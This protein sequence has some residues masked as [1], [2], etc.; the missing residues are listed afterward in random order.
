[1]LRFRSHSTQVARTETEVHRR[2]ASNRY[3]AQTPAWHA[4]YVLLQLQGVVEFGVMDCYESFE[5]FLGDLYLD[6]PWNAQGQTETIKLVLAD[7]RF[8][9]IAEDIQQKY[10][11]DLRTELVNAI[12][13]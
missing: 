11:F 9:D 12:A 10:G 3:P 4:E 6:M 1:M 13:K 7:I 5:D 8:P 2:L